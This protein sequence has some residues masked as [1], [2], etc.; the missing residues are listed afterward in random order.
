MVLGDLIDW[1]KKQDQD[2]IIKDGFGPVHSDPG[3]YHVLAFSPIPET[4]IDAMLG[5]AQAA[6]GWLGVS[7]LVNLHTPVLVA[8]EGE[9]GEYINSYTLKGW[10]PDAERVALPG[11]GAMLK[12]AKRGVW[13]PGE[14][15]LTQVD[16]EGEKG[17]IRIRLVTA[18]LK[19]LL[20]IEFTQEDW[21]RLTLGNERIVCDFRNIAKPE[22]GGG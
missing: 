18:E 2:R 19:G 8:K 7:S 9:G 10:A 11:I 5:H 4:T 14:L 20:D 1:L 17:P 12:P 22:E 13:Q 3:P 21:A 6:K 15:T 16:V